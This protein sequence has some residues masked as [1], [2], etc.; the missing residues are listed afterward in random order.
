MA[1]EGAPQLDRQGTPPRRRGGSSCPPAFLTLALGWAHLAVLPSVL[2]QVTVDGNRV[3]ES[4]FVTGALGFKVGDS[5][6]RDDVKHAVGK[7]N[8][9]GLFDDVDILGEDTS[10]GH[11]K[12]VVLVVEKRRVAKIVFK[13]NKKLDDAALK[14]KLTVKPGQ[15]FDDRLLADQIRALDQVYKEKGYS[16]VKIATEVAPVESEGPGRVELSFDIQEGEKVKIVGVR[17]TGAELLNPDRVLKGVKTKK[18]AWFW[19]GDFKEEVLREDQEL[20]A[21]NLHNSGYKDAPVPEYKLHFDP[22]KPYLEIEFIVVPGPFYE[23]GSAT[24]TGE[25]VLNESQLADVLTWRP[26]D[27]YSEAKI[28][29]AVS[30]V[31]AAYGEEGYLYVGVDAHK[32]T[33]ERRVDVDFRI[34]E[35]EPSRVRQVRITGNTK[36]KE[37]VVRR[38]IVIHPG[39][40]FSRSALVRS[41]REVFQLG[42]FEDVRVD[43]DRA[44]SST[45]DIDIIFDVKEKQTGTLQAGAGYSSD[46][47]LTG[48]IELGHNNLFGNGQQI[49]LKLENGSARSNQEL[50]FTEPWFL[51]TP[52]SAGFDLFN[53]TRVRDVYDDHRRGGAIRFGRNLPWPDYTSAFLSYRL[54]GVTISDVDPGIN[55][56]TAPTTTSSIAVTL[57]RNSTDNPFYPTTGVRTTLRSEFAGNFLGGNV[58][59][60]KYL[61]DSRTYVKTQWRPVLMLRGRGGLLA[62]FGGRGLVPDYET[63][64]LGGVTPQY[65]RGYPDYDVVPRGNDRFPGGRVAL[66]FTSELQFLIVEPVH[67]VFFFDAG[68][69]WNSTDDLRLTDLRKGAGFGVRLEIPLL[70]QMGFD[71]A[72]GFDREG[73]GRWE[74]HFMIGPQF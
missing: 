54:E 73:G 57:T 4:D 20:I 48:F 39:E 67:G 25:G 46:G 11:L 27:P 65:L 5:I 26:G 64:R 1:K 15:I 37:K 74:P 13:G 55:I 28:N 42:F 9:L 70:G 40:I 52:T 66:T 50:S 3:A 31:Y 49:S 18:K 6:T 17:L 12:L 36:T 43:F 10:P 19:G 51:D 58:N 38:Q 7:L 16:Q 22:K 14:E 32:E 8:G 71:Y 35:G 21:Q 33:T 47:G 2:D 63:F 45:S 60:Q 24:W 59:Y 72:F 23:M 34:T 29:D 30:A 69:T 56:S 44:G 53:V 68:D 61:L 41:Q 62:D